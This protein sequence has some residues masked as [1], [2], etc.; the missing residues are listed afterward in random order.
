MTAKA[1][2]W[3][4]R[5]IEQPLEDVY[6]NV[7]DYFANGH[8]NNTD[9]YS[10]M[11]DRAVAEGSFPKYIAGLAGK[12]AGD[13]FYGTADTGRALI[14][15][16][17]GGVTGAFKAATLN[18]GPELFDSSANLLKTSLN[19]YSLAAEQLGLVDQGTFAGFRATDAYNLTPVLNYNNDA[20]R[21]GAL[22]AGL[23]GG[24]ALGEFGDYNVRLPITVGDS[25][26]SMFGQAGSISFTP[27]NPFVS[28]EGIDLTLKYKSDWTEAQRAEATAKAQILNDASTVVTNSDRS[29][30]AAATSRY[31][32]AE[33][34]PAGRDIDHMVDL[35]LGGSKQIDNLWSLDSSVNRSLGAQV[36]HQIKDLPTGTRINRVTIED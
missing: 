22:V 20:E 25:V 1:P 4:E 2:S 16:P 23:L 27:Q 5:N 18:L 31:R 35:Q 10:A 7:A 30:T 34:P 12:K 13:I 8:Q 3:F 14:N 33:Q 26:P 11:Q 24:K 29:G 9:Y 17:A 36:Q 6:H 15:N 19:G 32:Q 28:N 21:G